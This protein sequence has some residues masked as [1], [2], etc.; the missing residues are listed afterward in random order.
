MQLSLFAPET[1]SIDAAAA[2]PFRET[3]KWIA[4][5]WRVL[6]ALSSVGLTERFVALGGTIAKAEIFIK[7]V[8]IRYKYK[9]SAATVFKFP[10]IKQL[11]RLIDE[12]SQIDDKDILVPIQPQ[13][14]RT[15]L[16]LVHTV[17]G[18]PYW[19]YAE[20]AR[21]LHT[22]QPIYGFRYTPDQS[23]EQCSDIKKM[24]ALYVERLRAFLPKGPYLI[25]GYC[26]GG[27]IAYEMARQLEAQGQR[28]QLVALFNSSPPNASY[29]QM[30]WTPR[31]MM[32]F[33]INIIHW[34]SLHRKQPAAVK[35]QYA[36]WKLVGLLKKIIRK[37]SRRKEYKDP[38]EQ[39]ID[40]KLFPQAL[41]PTVRNH[42]QS[43]IDYQA[44]PY[45]GAV[46]LIRTSAHSIFCSF[47]PLY[48]WQ[49]LAQGGVDL[50][51]IPGM[52][53]NMMS[54]PSVRDLAHA[55][56]QTLESTSAPSH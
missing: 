7:H 50:R 41:W 18:C 55:L 23:A 43:I 3:E 8:A 36:R 35:Y 33:T 51:V 11:A 6:L 29:D 4:Q 21:Y 22:D 32:L 26:F 24:A 10:T 45:S 27:N 1:L 30:Q 54:E 5:E 19:G 16:F 44:K 28:P 56:T 52:H 2:P 42:V 47:D 9:L 53:E 25:G 38:C 39:M 13:G 20:I 31:S 49:E 48:G 12:K 34:L 14:N 40:F 15:P 17:G 46:S 37:F